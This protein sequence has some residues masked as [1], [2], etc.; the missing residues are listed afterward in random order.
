M[1]YECIVRLLRNMVDDRKM[2][3]GIKY[4]QDKEFSGQT[5]A[6]LLERTAEQMPQ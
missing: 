1:L 2:S 5:V 4:C 6:L 3:T